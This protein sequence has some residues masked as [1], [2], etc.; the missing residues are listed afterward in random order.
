MRS[1]EDAQDYRYFPEPDLMPV[2][3]GD[4][5]VERIRASLPELASDRRRRYM[6]EL[7]LAE[8]DARLITGDPAIADLFDGAVGAGANAKK[9]ANYIMSE[10]MRKGKTAGEDGVVIGISGVQLAELIALVEKGDINLVSSRDILD[11]IWMT[12]MTPISA[13][14]TKKCCPSLSDSS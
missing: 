11:K 13:R 14:E 9:A 3:L 1:K 2:V 12:A 7:G 6:S 5:D 4:E 8:Y 10:I